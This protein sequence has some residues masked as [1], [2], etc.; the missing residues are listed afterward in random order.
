MRAAILGL[1]EGRAGY[2]RQAFEAAGLE[3]A[4]A[5]GVNGLTA[6]RPQ[7]L[8]AKTAYYP[9]PAALFS[10]EEKL[11]LVLVSGAPET[12]FK[13]ALLALENRTHAVCETPFCFSTTDFEALREAAAERKLSLGALQ[14]WEQTSAWRAL[15]KALTQRLL[16]DVF[17][18]QAQ[19]LRAGPAPASGETAADGWQ[20]FAMLLAAVRTPPSAL[21]ARLLPPP[22]RE[23]ARPDSSG[24][25][26]V[27]FGGADGAAHAAAGFHAG[28]VRVSA[29][30]GNG[31]LDLD[32]DLLRIDVK[33]APP[34][35]VRYPE[36]LCGAGGRPE[37]L[38]AELKDFVKEINLELPAGSSLRNSR[39]C[40]KLLKNA[41][42]SASLR[43]SAVPL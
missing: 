35:S 23:A 7:G 36:G 22:D 14:P 12:R 38:A 32:G 31:R 18:A 34:E 10:K 5:C 4:A 1:E 41:Y 6:A 21:S 11:E 20:A 43:S 15:E 24:S 39:Y 25:F 37:L 17:W 8:P 19:V 2:F 42:Y 16:G 3:L 26:L 33:G 9:G 29:A 13:A 30:G 28:R 27:H 40:V